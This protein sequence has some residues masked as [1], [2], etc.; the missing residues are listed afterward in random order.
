MADR[1]SRKRDEE[2][3]TASAMIV[4]S[5]DNILP[6]TIINQSLEIQREAWQFF[7][8]LGEVEFAIGDWLANAMSRVRLI[9]AI[10]QPGEEPTPIADD[11]QSVNAKAVRQL[12]GEL[13]G[14]I[15]GQA[16][17]MKRFAVHLSVPGESYLVGT[18][19]PVTGRRAWRIYSNDEIRSKGRRR[20]KNGQVLIQYDVNV[21]MG[22]WET[23]PIDSLV[24]RIWNP[25]E[26]FHFMAFSAL[27]AALSICR[28]IDMYNRYIISQLVSRMALNGILFVPTE[29]TFPSKPQFKDEPD[30]FIAEI[31]DLAGKAIKN[32][33]S[34][35]A[36]MPLILKVPAAMIEKFRLLESSS[37]MAEKVI[38]NRQAALDRLAVSIN[39]PAEILQGVAKMN[40][41]G[42]WQLEESAVKIHINPLAEIICM[43]LV[44]GYLKTMMVV[45]GLDL[46]APDGGT[47]I[48]WYDSSALVQQPDTSER[49]FATYDRGTMSEE[50][51]MR[52]AS[53]E[54]EDMPTDDEFKTIALKKI[55][56]GGG[57]NAL[58]ALAALTGDESLVPPPPVAPPGES[59]DGGP[60]TGEASP[61]PSGAPTSPG[62]PGGQTKAPPP[63]RPGGTRP[64]GASVNI[65]NGLRVRT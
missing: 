64:A 24:V 62:S 33:G 25:D 28:E 63:T 7:H 35:A 19:D 52:E 38:E 39:I 34:A 14:G 51:L 32:P 18:D 40:H 61:T 57:A 27:Q 11:D 9:P 12:V 1:R 56:M 5:G 2:D 43:G 8:S 29:V 26:Q 22:Q 47:Y 55:A 60:G 10:Q 17:M 45:N 31:M 3:L 13:G 49:A 23:L 65:A 36:A 44:E 6:Q 30:P 46:I 58:Q 59:T 20:Q 16:A 50:A 53:F 42:Q 37:I 48:I 4:S 21:A 54:P 41:W 15:G